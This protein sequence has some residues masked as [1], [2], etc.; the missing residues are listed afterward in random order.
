[1]EEREETEEEEGVGGGVVGAWNPNALCVG[2]EGSEEDGICAA[3]GSGGA[4]T[5]GWGCSSAR[6][7]I[8]E[9]EVPKFGRPMTLG[10]GGVFGI[11]LLPVAADAAFEGVRYVLFSDADKEEDEEE[12]AGLGDEP[13]SPA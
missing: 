2:V 6:G 3:C 13:D 11:A 5:V 12:A 4:T 10:S 8:R 1:V 9:E 7:A